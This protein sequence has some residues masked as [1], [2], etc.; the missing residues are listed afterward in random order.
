MLFYIFLPE[1]SLQFI[2]MEYR[3]I[4]E[5]IRKYRRRLNLTQD[6]LAD[7]VGVTWE[8]ISRYE[9]GESSPMNKLDKLSNALNIRVTDLLSENGCADY[10]I[11]LFA[12]IPK[13][14]E[15]KRKNTTLSYNCPRW[16]IKLDPEVFA[17]DTQLVI[18]DKEISSKEGYL[19][20]SPNSEIKNSDLILI[21]DDSKL[22][23]E[24][25]NNNGV[26]P[27]GKVMMQEVI[28]K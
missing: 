24:V 4:G 8:M 9:R 17:I 27:I 5:S 16:L 7:R 26:I 25:F 15:F 1:N 13:A 6:Q 28:F 22:R 10:N 18:Q 23:V 3:D 11:P 20:I 12:K 19:F 2:Y 21:S 14:F